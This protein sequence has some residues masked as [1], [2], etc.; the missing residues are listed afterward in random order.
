MT[1]Q[2][3]IAD[4]RKQHLNRIKFGFTV[5]FWDKNHLITDKWHPGDLNHQ[6]HSSQFWV[7]SDLERS[8]FMVV[9]LQSTMTMFFPGHT[10][11]TLSS[12]TVVKVWWVFTLGV[13]RL[14]AS[15]M[16]RRA[17]G[18]LPWRKKHH[19]PVKYWSPYHDITFQVTVIIIYFLSTAVLSKLLSFSQFFLDM[20]VIYISG[21]ILLFL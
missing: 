19:F 20:S 14:R 18:I 13:I 9:L 21:H 1:L 16:W 8:G 10:F 15:G 12:K 5:S 17:E 3:A 2:L 7:W 4:N 11:W 6:N